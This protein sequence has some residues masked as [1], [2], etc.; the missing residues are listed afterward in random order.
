[1][2]AAGDYDNDGD[3]DYSYDDATIGSKE[4][5]KNGFG[6]NGY[7]GPS[8]LTPGQTKSPIPDISPPQHGVGGLRP[9]DTLAHRVK[10]G[11]DGKA[12]PYASHP[13]MAA[14]GVSDGSP[15][16]KIPAAP[17][18]ADSGKSISPGTFGRKQ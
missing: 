18:R 3:S 17:H 14:R 11:D 7:Q 12:Q 16:G 2:S 10:M 6:Q 15:G 1:M 4:K 9:E 13:S 8:S 5:S